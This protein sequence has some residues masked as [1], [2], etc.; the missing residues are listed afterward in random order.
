[1]TII[2]NSTLKSLNHKKNSHVCVMSLELLCEKITSSCNVF[3]STWRSNAHEI[4]RYFKIFHVHGCYM[5][6]K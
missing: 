3:G 6:V 4:A 1:M 5:M 2:G